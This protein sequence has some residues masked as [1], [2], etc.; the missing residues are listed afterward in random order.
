MFIASKLERSWFGTWLWWLRHRVLFMC[1]DPQTLNEKIRYKMVHDRRPILTLLA[2]KYAV[3]T[4]VADR[5]GRQALTEVYAVVADP[6]AIPWQALPK[7]F[8]LKAT[9]GSG[10]TILA[11]DRTSPDVGIPDFIEKR[12]W[13]VLARI[14]PDRLQA[15]PRRDDLLHAWLRSNYWRSLGKTEWAYRDIPPR[16]IIEELL[17]VDGDSP[18]DYKLYC[19]DGRVAFLQVIR[20][21]LNGG[22]QERYTP[23]WAPIGESS[24]LVVADEPAPP[25][26]ILPEL[27]E[28]ASKI[29]AGIDFVRVDL[30]DVNGR[31]VFGEVTNYPMAGSPTLEPESLFSEMAADWEPWRLQDESAQGLKVQTE[32]TAQ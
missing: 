10:A 23:N 7:R 22:H 3:R 16:L 5:V 24:R 31:V 15:D 19:F 4:Y 13:G 6:D 8:A 21:R 28:T 12:P 30:Y 11:D 17:E 2:D 18:P 9:H 32:D 1:R 20:D 29:S 27:L 14:H 25:P 26:H